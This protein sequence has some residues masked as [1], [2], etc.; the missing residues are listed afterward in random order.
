MLSNLTCSRLLL[1]YFNRDL[2]IK[3]Q[4]YLP[5][6]PAATLMQVGDPIVATGPP[7]AT[8]K[9]ADPARFYVS[10]GPYTAS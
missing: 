10:S 4:Y 9:R 6:P 8:L 3:S 7:A 5:G 1:G 2:K